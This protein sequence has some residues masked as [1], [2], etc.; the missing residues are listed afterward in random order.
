MMDLDR[1]GLMIWI[2][3]WGKMIIQY[4]IISD[5][6]PKYWYFRRLNMKM[7]MWIYEGNF[8]AIWI[9]S[10]LKHKRFVLSIKFKFLSSMFIFKD[11]L[12]ILARSLFYR[13]TETTWL[14]WH[15][16]SL[17]LRKTILSNLNQNRQVDLSTGD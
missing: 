10:N 3:Y 1:S 17:C 16:Y 9:F 8:I 7:I 14:G 13:K 15:F 12:I 4:Q 6:I 11:Y 5:D 2:W